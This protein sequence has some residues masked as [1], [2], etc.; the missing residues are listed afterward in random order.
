M[1]DCP[2]GQFRIKKEVKA[3]AREKVKTDKRDSFMLVHS[4]RT[5]LIP[6]VYKRSPQ[7]RA[8]QRFLRQRAFYV[9]S[10]SRTK[11]KIRSLL[12]QQRGEF[13]DKVSRKRL[14]Q[15]GVC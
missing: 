2:Q 11:N 4:L 12:A 15:K 9:G 10:I 5:D 8:Y 1:T 13:R 14:P 7:N 6:E 3:I